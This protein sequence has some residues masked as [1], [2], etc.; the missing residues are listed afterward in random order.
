MF[1]KPWWQQPCVR[2]ADHSIDSLGVADEYRGTARGGTRV[3]Y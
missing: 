1:V 3:I 2:H